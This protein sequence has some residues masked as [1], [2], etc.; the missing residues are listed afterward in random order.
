MT[1][2][3]RSHLIENV[4]LQLWS[5]VAQHHELG[6]L[7][8]WRDLRIEIREDI[9]VGLDSFARR[10]VVGV[11][12]LPVEGLSDGDFETGRVDAAATE[13]VDRFTRE[14]LADDA[15]ESDVRKL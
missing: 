7:K 13:H 6:I 1:S 3:G 4:Q 10:E 14:V 15:H 11:A 12:T 5:D 2:F 9:E 8:R